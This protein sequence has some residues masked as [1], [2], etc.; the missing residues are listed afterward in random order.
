M[1]DETK[2][3][4]DEIRRVMRAVGAR[5]GMAGRGKP[6]PWARNRPRCLRCGSFLGA[7]SRCARC[8]Q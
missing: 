4:P 5:G 3:T 8:G 2:P 7:A 1:S 6:K